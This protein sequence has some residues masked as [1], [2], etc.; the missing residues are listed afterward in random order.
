MLGILHFCSPNE[1]DQSKPAES[2]ALSHR[3]QLLGKLV[4]FPTL[5]FGLIMLVVFQ[6]SLYR[7]CL[8]KCLRGTWFERERERVP[9]IKSSLDMIIWELFPFFYY[10]L[11]GLQNCG[12]FHV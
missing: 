12:I 10:I 5:I 11:P 8:M 1:I 9:Q 7:I 2:F 3:L 4:L 6:F